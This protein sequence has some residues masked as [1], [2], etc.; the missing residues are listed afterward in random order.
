MENQGGIKEKKKKKKDRRKDI[1][2]EVNSRWERMKKGKWRSGSPSPLFTL[3]PMGG[4]GG[5]SSWTLQVRAD[6][7]ASPR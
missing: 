6:N 3:F 4:Q 5:G 2:T 7:K 1:L